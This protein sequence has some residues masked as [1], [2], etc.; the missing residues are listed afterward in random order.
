MIIDQQGKSMIEASTIGSLRNVNLSNTHEPSSNGKEEPIG[1]LQS[2]YHHFQD[3][4]VS[5]H[6]DQG[7]DDEGGDYG[8]RK[9]M[10]NED[11]DEKVELPNKHSSS[12]QLYSHLAYEH[13]QQNK[14][15]S[16]ALGGDLLMVPHPIMAPIYS[17]MMPFASPPSVDS[18]LV[19][20]NPKQ[21]NRILQRRQARARL[22][23]RFKILP[24][25]PYLHP[26]R[27]KHA[28]KR[29]RGPGGRFLSQEEKK[30]RNKSRKTDGNCEE[31]EQNFQEEGM[32][33]NEENKE[34]EGGELDV[35]VGGEQEAD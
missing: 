21:Y 8:G 22:G 17:H 24:R 34:E 19:Y 5:S 4:E 9:S 18:E 28:T 14:L 32:L 33:S 15:N 1:L 13:S 6:N 29:K 10:S 26:S 12:D 7:S 27:H 23:L 20:V 16:Q 3:Y 35:G 11:S 30:K 2:R 25:Q 31:E